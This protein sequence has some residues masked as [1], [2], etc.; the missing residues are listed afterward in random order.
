ME[1]AGGKLSG[2]YCE[3]LTLLFCADLFASYG[4]L[5]HLPPGI[6]NRDGNEIPMSVAKAL[7]LDLAGVLPNHCDRSTAG[8]HLAR[9]VAIHRKAQQGVAP[10]T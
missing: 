9:L 2:F 4:H 5:S 10:D 6:F 1:D 8:A 7:E 3:R